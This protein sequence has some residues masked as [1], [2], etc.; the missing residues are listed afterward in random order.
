MDLDRERRAWTLVY[1][2]LGVVEGGTAGVMVRALFADQVAGPLVDL[3]LAMVTSAP[4]WANI[5]SLVYAKR[6]QGRPK[7][8]FLQPLLFAMALCVAALGLLPGGPAG[9]L[10]F[11]VIYCTCR[12][13]WAGVETVRAVLWSVNYP[14]RLRAR[15]TGRITVLTSVALAASSLGLGWLLEHEGHAYR[16]ALLAAA[17]CGVVGAVAIGGLRVR[18]EHDLLDAERARV[19]AGATFS[20]A[21]IR[22]LLARDADFRHYMQAMT[23]FGAGNL[24]LTPLLVI[25]YD[26]VLHL[27]T[28]TQ[29]ALTTA[30]PVL[31]IPL[32]IQPWA[33][34]LDRQHV[35]VFRSIH[36][37]VTVAAAALLLSGVLASA[38]GLL[39]PGAMLMGI[40]L[41]GA[42]LGWS[43]GHNDFA[44]RGEETRYMALHVTLTG[45]RGLVA[46]P[47]GIAAYYLLEELRPGLGP[48]AL[49][50]PLALLGAGAREF[51]VLRR[52]RARKSRAA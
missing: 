7:I 26:D 36:G 40:S 46:P 49:F 35:V 48:W 4:A 38:P 10:L 15:I 5:A 16:Y 52:A 18:R 27:P 12:L 20:Y 47:I 13:L 22:E 41:A 14:R 42:S 39:W 2:C 19:A 44:P 6:V 28:L 43:L 50:L 11:F 32:A 24:M 25:G 45:V 1:V 17:C 8:A 31:I 3:V 51:N 30:L 21:G 33:H 23:L 34:Y 37:W 9:L 29:V